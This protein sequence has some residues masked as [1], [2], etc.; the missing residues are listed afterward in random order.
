MTQ[1]KKTPPKR[2]RRDF[3]ARSLTLTPV[4]ETALRQIRQDAS[5][6]LGWTVGSSAVVRALLQYAAHHGTSW[7]QGSLF[8]LIEREIKGGLFWGSRKK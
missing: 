2:T 1:T 3:I 8:P 5:D 6:S 4:A 7:A